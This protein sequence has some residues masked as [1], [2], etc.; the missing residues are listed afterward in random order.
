MHP[1]QE[2]E[3]QCKFNLTLT[4][5]TDTNNQSDNPQM[6]VEDMVMAFLLHRRKMHQHTRKPT[7]EELSNLPEVQITEPSPCNQ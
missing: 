7:E 3:H 2:I 4:G 6:I 1:H 5:F